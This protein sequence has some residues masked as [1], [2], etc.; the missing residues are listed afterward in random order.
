[1]VRRSDLPTVPPPFNVDRFAKDS[2]AKLRAPADARTKGEAAS[3]AKV[4]QAP[5]RPE[6]TDD[7]AAKSERRLITRPKM[8]AASSNEAWA[9]SMKGT[10]RVVVP[11]SSLKGMPL[12]HRAGYLLSWMD[13]MIDL[14][15]LV[16]VSTMPR[17]EVLTIVRDLY[18]AGIVEFR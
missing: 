12:D 2:D 10:P 4:K 13:G 3:E 1:M 15:T 14:D 18:E 8:E 17:A 16:E 9:R 5:E 7:P 6:A 11:V